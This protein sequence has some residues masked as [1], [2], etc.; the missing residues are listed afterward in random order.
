MDKDEKAK[1][2]GWSNPNY[3]VTE[4]KNTQRKVFSHYLSICVLSFFLAVICKTTG[5][6]WILYVVYFYYS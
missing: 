4:G 2:A 3:V 5:K 6:G 1:Q